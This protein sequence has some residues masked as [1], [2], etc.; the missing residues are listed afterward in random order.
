MY[1][2]DETK[3]VDG[4]TEVTLY[5]KAY[6]GPH[7]RYPYDT[8]AKKMEEH[9]KNGVRVHVIS[10]PGFLM[11]MNH[12]DNFFDDDTRPWSDCDGSYYKTAQDCI[13]MKNGR[14]FDIE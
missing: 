7:G 4:V 2:D 10:V 14:E 6:T 12:F 8:L 3:V 1:L 13:S 5:L 9:H 11:A